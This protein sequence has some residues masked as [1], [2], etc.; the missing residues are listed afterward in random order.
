MPL[1]AA[2]CS[3]ALILSLFAQTT[4]SPLTSLVFPFFV[5]GCA[6]AIKDGYPKKDAVWFACLAWLISLAVSAFVVAPVIVINAFVWFLAI[7]PC[8]ALCLH[9]KHVKACITGFTIVLGLYAANLIGQQ[10]FHVHYIGF[11]VDGHGGR[12]WPLIDPNNAACVLNAAVMTF[13]YMTLRRVPWADWLFALFVTAL[14]ITK[15]R[16]GIIS[17]G[18]GCSML[19]AERYKIWLYLI[20]AEVIVAWAAFLLMLQW[21]IEWIMLAVNSMQARY[22]IWDTAWKIF[23]FRPWAGVGIGKFI[24]YYNQIRTETF[25][26]GTFAHNDLL[27]IA[28]EMGAPI[29]L[30]FIALWAIFLT[31]RRHIVP[32]CYA[33]AVILQAMVEFQFYMPNVSILLGVALA[34]R[35][36]CNKK[37]ATL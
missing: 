19:V 5:A 8:M 27:Q 3:I 17:A 22:P 1:V 12:S 21:K 13:F 35:G 36:G 20:L 30:V 28:C 4:A 24:F 18:V 14:L 2:F 10:I 33:M 29:S 31:A 11:N 25:S 16:A 23:M 7:M 6:V 26:A 15:S 32:A 37:R 9:D 34:Y